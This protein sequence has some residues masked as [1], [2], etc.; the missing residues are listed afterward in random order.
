MRATH[1]G[2]LYHCHRGLWVPLDAMV[3]VLRD[4]QNWGGDFRTAVR[5]DTWYYSTY[6]TV[7]TE[8][9]S[10]NPLQ[11][12]MY[13]M[14][15][16]EWWVRLLYIRYSTLPHHAL[17]I[18]QL[19]L[20]AGGLGI[21]D[22]RTR[23]IPD[24]MLTFTTSTQHATNGIYL[25]KHLNNVHL[26]LTI[27]A[28]YSTSTNPHSIILKRF[29]HILPNIVTSSCLPTIPRTD[30]AQYFLTTLS[31]HSARERLKKHSTGII[32][33]E[34]YNHVF[35]HQHKHFHLLPSILSP[36][37]SY[38]LIAMTRSCIKNCLTPLTFLLCIRRKLRLPVYPNRT[39]CTCGHHEHDIYGDHAFS[40][41]RGSK[42]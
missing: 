25:N 9:T 26:H 32:T 24:F 21:L 29:Y 37:T 31:P 14:V 2:W 1:L 27:A 38:P 5:C 30:L 13:F 4:P 18:A 39:P 34:L 3:V 17:L 28:L 7:E 8:Q 12:G 33:A 36:H 10:E 16:A 42:K 19:S 23:A 11:S 41:D 22:P 15:E 20:N 40:C 35:E 6:R